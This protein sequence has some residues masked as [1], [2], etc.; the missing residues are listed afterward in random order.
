MP[1]IHN[2]TRHIIRCLHGRAA[3]AAKSGSNG[4]NVH[5]RHC[6]TSELR[7]GRLLQSGNIN[8]GYLTRGY[9]SENHIISSTY[10]GWPIPGGF[11]ST[12]TLN[13]SYLWGPNG[14]PASDR[15]QSEL[16]FTS[17]SKRTLKNKRAQNS[18]PISLASFHW[19]GDTLLFTTNG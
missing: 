6:R 3:D 1:P 14:H 18:S 13:F 16:R 11:Q 19:D 8:S 10:S 4:L 9:D 12:W 17:Q 7:S 15:F 5:V 2:R